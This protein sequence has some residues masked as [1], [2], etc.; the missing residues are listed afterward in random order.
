MND[1]GKPRKTNITIINKLPSGPAFG[2][3]DD[4]GEHVFITSRIA[5]SVQADIGMRFEAEYVPNSMKDKTPWF[6]VRLDTIKPEIKEADLRDRLWNTIWAR[7]LTVTEE[8]CVDRLVTLM[9]DLG[10]KITVD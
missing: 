10:V 9:R 3:R 4:T 8:Q 7:D 1:T 6:A 5:T 2:V